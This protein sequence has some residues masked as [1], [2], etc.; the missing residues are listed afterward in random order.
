[1]WARGRFLFGVIAMLLQVS[2]QGDKT[3]RVIIDGDTINDEHLAPGETQ[4]IET[5]DEGKVEFK[6]MGA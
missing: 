6:E 5:V 2:N 1:L 4:V 3:V